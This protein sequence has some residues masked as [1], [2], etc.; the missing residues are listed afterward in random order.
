MLSTHHYSPYLWAQG[1]GNA[2][3]IIKT[4]KEERENIK[5]FFLAVVRHYTRRTIL[6][7]LYVLRRVRRGEKKN[8][9]R[10]AR[11][12]SSQGGKLIPGLIR[13]TWKVI[14]TWGQ[15]QQI[16]ILGSVANDNRWI[17][18]GTPGNTI[19]SGIEQ[20]RVTWTYERAAAYFTA[21]TRAKTCECHTLL[22]AL[23][24]DYCMKLWYRL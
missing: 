14:W 19:W 11:V 13:Q 8:K 18:S 3:V 6:Q 9:T 23:N 16:I 1:K 5:R 20:L 21:I 24:D 12:T 22:P 15:T 7:R 17:F 4:E 10:L 2:R